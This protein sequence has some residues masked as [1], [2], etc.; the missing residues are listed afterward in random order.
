MSR[1]RDT[2]FGSVSA[3]LTVIRNSMA[4]RT[5]FLE[6]GLACADICRAI[7]RGMN[8]RQADHFNQSVFEVIEQ[9]TTTVSE[10]QRNAD[11]LYESELNRI[12]HV[13]NTELALNTHVSVLKAQKLAMEIYRTAVERREGA[14]KGDETVT[15]EVVF[16]LGT[17][18][19][20]LVVTLNLIKKTFSIC[21][22]GRLPLLPEFKLECRTG[23]SQEGIAIEIDAKVIKGALKFSVKDKWS[24]LDCDA[25]VLNKKYTGTVKLVPVE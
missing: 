2:V 11:K 9:L 20:R 7:D 6:L 8:C 13:F 16:N 15:H 22:Y 5:E 10:I 19:I 18:T 1:V 14:D 24:L 23:S 12:L 21:S 3:L 17:L 25:A 4:K